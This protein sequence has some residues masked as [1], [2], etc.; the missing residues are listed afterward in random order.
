MKSITKAI[1]LILIFLISCD[2]PSFNRKSSS[3]IVYESVTVNLDPSQLHEFY[4]NQMVV[5]NI[6]SYVYI[7]GIDVDTMKVENLE[8]KSDNIYIASNSKRARVDFKVTLKDKSKSLK[9][10]VPIYFFFDLSENLTIGYNVLKDTTVTFNL[11][12]RNSSLQFESVSG[13]FSPAEGKILFVFELKNKGSG[14]LY[15]SDYYKTAKKFDERAFNNIT[16]LI[17]DRPCEVGKIID[18]RVLVRCI[19]ETKE[20]KEIYAHNVTYSGVVKLTLQY[21]YLIT[22]HININYVNISS[23]DSYER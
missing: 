2:Y 14:M 10:S 20:G 6:N 11:P 16:I 8:I 19:F 21:G 18:E 9:I 17:D 23:F 7:N 3:E 13:K 12:S 5:A 1:L 4:E 22:K 15:S